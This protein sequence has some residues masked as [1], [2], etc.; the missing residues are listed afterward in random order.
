MLQIGVI[1]NFHQDC[2][3][4]GLSQ[5]TTTLAEG[6]REKDQEYYAGVINILLSLEKVH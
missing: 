2:H 6:A 4:I 3:N 5:S 1:L